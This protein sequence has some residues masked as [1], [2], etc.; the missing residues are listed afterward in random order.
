MEKVKTGFN[1]YI[2]LSKVRSEKE[3]IKVCR[4]REMDSANVSG[5]TILMLSLISSSAKKGWLGI[6]KLQ[7]LSFLIEYLLMKK[8]Q[9]GSGYEFFMY[10]QGPISKGVYNDLETL[11]DREIIVEDEKGIR[12][13]DFGDSIN[14]QFETV[15]PEEVRSV[16]QYVVG[17]YARMST[18]ELVKFVHDMKMK[19]PDG[20]TIRIDD[21][22]RSCVLLPEAQDKSFVVKSNVL[23]T[24]AIMSH[25]SLINS[26]RATR[27]NGS[28]SKPYTPLVS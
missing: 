6:T 10:D 8:G 15:I 25:K 24:F 16:M 19:L 12:A 27:K 3:N 4:V 2:G 26:I 7:K 9:R 5:K 17:H 18:H 11:L 28:K 23:E 14:T 13:S 20:S 22:S 1:S 21:I